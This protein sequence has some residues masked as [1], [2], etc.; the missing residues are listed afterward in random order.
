MSH[1]WTAADDFHHLHFIHS[2]EWNDSNLLLVM[3]FQKSVKPE[4]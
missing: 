3:G 2:P 1:S 4:Y